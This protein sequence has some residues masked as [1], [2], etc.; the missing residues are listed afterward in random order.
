MELTALYTFIDDFFKEIS[1]FECW[2]ELKAKWLGSRGPK[3]KL[4]LS[5]IVTLNILRFQLRITDLKSFHRLV[6]ERYS[7]EFPSIPNYEN[8]L[9]ATNKSAEFTLLII[10]YLLYINKTISK[11]QNH[12]IDSTPLSVCYNYN[13][14]S[15]KVNRGTA[16]RGKSTKGWFYGFKLHGICNE[17]GQLEKI[18][19]TPGNVH[20]SKTLEGMVSG[21]TGTMTCDAGYLVKD[22]I[23]EKIFTKKM[24][25][26]IATRKNMKRIMT[27]EQGRLF[28]V[29]SRIETV[30]GVLKERFNL[31][32]TLARSTNGLFRHYFY[33]ITSF[34]LDNYE[35]KFLSIG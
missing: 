18:F 24:K 4:S 14:P 5:E 16:A 33:S 27:K 6:K 12:F 13:I 9:K 20:A 31:I 23:L 21:L 10:K 7:E 11:N 28:K 32:Y 8:F 22:E 29:R 26:Y 35:R 17:K 30:W 15:H 19:F 34:L 3:K 2:T 1:T 25:M